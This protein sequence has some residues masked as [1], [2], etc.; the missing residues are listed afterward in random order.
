MKSTGAGLLLSLIV[1]GLWLTSSNLDGK[2]LQYGVGGPLY[3]VEL[4]LFPTQHGEPAGYPGNLVD[5]KGTFLEGFSPSGQFPQFQNY[6]GSVENFRYYWYHYMPVR[7]M[8]DLQSLLKNFLAKDLRPGSL[9]EYAAP[10]YMSPT[11]GNARNTGK[12]NAPVQ[13]LRWKAG[14]PAFE[15]DLGE[16]KE[17]MYAVRI[18]GAV[19]T[20]K[21]LR[22]RSPLILSMTVNDAIDGSKNT[23]IQRCGYVDEFYSV[24][25]FYFHAPET[26]NYRVSLTM[27]DRS[28]V[29]LL[30]HN[31][32][33]H[34]VL[35]GTT[36]RALK[37]TSLN[38][39]DPM[40]KPGMKGDTRL[41][42]ERL[43]RDRLLWESV[44]PINAQSGRIFGMAADDGKD[45]WPNM[46]A[47][48]MTE[49]Q[50]EEKYGK[51]GAVG[52]KRR[53]GIDD[54]IANSYILTRNEKLGIS[55]TME[56]YIH[57]RP[58]PDPYPFKDDGRGIFTPSGDPEK[59]GQNLH[60]VADAIRD[61]WSSILSQHGHITALVNEFKKGNY[62]AGRDAAMLL[63]AAVYQY[64]AFDSRTAMSAIMV[65]PGPY[66]RDMALRRR[67]N[68][69]F[70]SFRDHADS[71]DVL[72]PII[73][74][75]QQLADSINRFVP[76]VKTPDDVVKLFD[77]YLLQHLAKGY[78]RYQNQVANQPHAVALLATLIGDNEF[79]LP[80][81]QW[82]FSRSFTYPQ[83]PSGI[84][85]MLV[86]GF[87][88]DGMNYIGSTYYVTPSIGSAA[89]LDE[90]VKQGGDPQ[91]SLM[92]PVRYPKVYE[93][94]YMSLRYHTAALQF[95]RTG[96]VTGPEK[97]L[98]FK[99]PAL[100]AS[101]RRGWELTKDPKFAWIL[102]NMGEKKEGDT[103]EWEPIRKA[104]AEQKR[105]PWLENRSR[106]LSNLA[107]I[108]ETGIEHDDYRFRRSVGLRIGQGFGHAHN[109]TL[110][111]QLHAHGIPMMIGGGQRHGY[112]HP[113]D[114]ATCA[115]A[116]V[117]VDGKNHFTHAWI[118]S[119]TD[120][121]GARYM[122]SQAAVTEHYERQI[123]LI[124]V[125]EG[126][127]SVPL[128]PEKLKPG[129]ELATDVE[130]AKSYVFD[131]FRVAGGGLHSYAF[132]ANTGE[133]IEANP[134]NRT[135]V[136]A[137]PDGNREAHYLR[138]HQ[139]EKWVGDAPEYFTAAIPISKNAEKTFLSPMWSED[140][141]R[142][143]TKLH[144]LPQDGT[145]ALFGLKYT[146]AGGLKYNMPMVYLQRKGAELPAA[147]TDAEA[148]KDAGPT[149]ER[150]ESVFV[151][152]IEPYAGK[153][154]IDKV[155]RIQVENNEAGAMQA[156]AAKV[157]LKD[158]RSDVCFADSGTLKERRFGDH[159]ASAEFG[160]VSTD[161]DG[162]RQATLSGGTLLEAPGLVIRSVAAERSGIITEAD[163]A[164]KRFK[165]D[166]AWSPLAG[167]ERI[168][169]I[170][171]P[172]KWTQYTLLEAEP[173][174]AGS[175][176]KVRGGADYYLSRV[177][178][179]DSKHSI[180]CTGVEIQHT[181]L[182]KNWTAS[183]ES[184]TKFWRADYIG[185]DREA[186]KFKFKLSGA[187]V[188]IEDFGELG[189]LYLWEY[190][191]G[192]SVRQ[193][194]NVN[195]RRTAK[196]QY[197][198]AANVAVE[199]QIGGKTFTV[200]Q[201]QLEKNNGVVTLK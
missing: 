199:I 31:V 191:V 93:S 158:G 75:N 69:G 15:L 67:I 111:M 115:S 7:N 200:S 83:G 192:D 85:D 109:D 77:V 43:N 146:E 113:T 79:T 136:T 18:I 45:N 110:A 126:R 20:E 138:R 182:D 47:A 62:D 118:P 165:L 100:L 101:A 97:G 40:A 19:Q 38:E 6:P 152:V 112:S 66:G 190:G 185:G 16:L 41:I 94:L 35:A 48:G 135:H 8:F 177:S 52:G 2:D 56:D 162:L 34:D 33:V 49:G 68:M 114:V 72:F 169:Q 21:L 197:E 99:F 65:N 174:E 133:E 184:G 30:V 127:G 150:I 137:L 108:L 159:K 5:E 157:T 76:W 28:M 70:R 116:L 84:H 42:E 3:G 36:R 139:G 54:F 1:S 189:G 129:S 73:Q 50:I 167:G 149:R 173:K 17:G 46:G 9:E 39:L 102:A 175:W 163:Y 186:K 57:N 13:V 180:V 91:F 178:E 187:P 201:E 32:D 147:T 121:A 130:T 37:R 106:A 104:A 10:L 124:D 144:A 161:G 11:W 117:E 90:Y 53:G 170:G 154:F 119:L 142:H 123:A 89:I 181:G 132:H 95:F 128:P 105:A 125:D 22:H 172:E 107:G 155:E 44:P 156:V 196:G 164:A 140:A 27:D 92:D 188:S 122:R 160:F 143:V 78:L 151:A 166:Q 198:L 71:Y 176:I 14:D 24:A 153:P 26:R 168:A 87:D 193:P 88:R 64:P 148:D 81:M 179:V 51:W 4:P 171:T 61:R 96:S 25:E 145:R 23:Y 98:G 74:G 183:N 59:P 141:P 55:Y 194:T 82:T 29:D 103:E 120:A 86:S 63:A 12:F 58:L 134:L 131:V 80:W 60:P 195:L